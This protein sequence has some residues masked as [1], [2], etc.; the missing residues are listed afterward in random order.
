MDGYAVAW[1]VGRWLGLNVGR[2]SEGGAAC[3]E[4]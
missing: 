4:E 2:G 1:L 3:A